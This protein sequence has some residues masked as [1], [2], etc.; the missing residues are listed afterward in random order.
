MKVQYKSVSVLFFFF[1][2]EISLIFITF[3]FLTAQHSSWSAH[4]KGDASIRPCVLANHFF[5]RHTR[6]RLVNFR[7]ITFQHRCCLGLKLERNELEMNSVKTQIITMIWVHYRKNKKI[8]EVD[9]QW[10]NI[11]LCI[12]ILWVYLLLLRSHQSKSLAIPYAVAHS[13]SQL[14]LLPTPLSSAI[15]SWCLLAELSSL[16]GPGFNL[17]YII[18]RVRTGTYVDVLSEEEAHPARRPFS[19]TVVILPTKLRS[20]SH[21]TTSIMSSS[22]TTPPIAESMHGSGSPPASQPTGYTLLMI[23]APWNVWWNWITVE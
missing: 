3:A 1:R 5:C 21:K 17:C 16:A 14:P 8:Q 23:L 2:T 7:L 6:R 13:P 10:S 18:G 9:C 20:S 22:P 4:C 15:I 12:L 11:S 19:L